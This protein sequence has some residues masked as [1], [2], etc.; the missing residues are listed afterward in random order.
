MQRSAVTALATGAAS[1]VP[2]W[3]APRGVRAAIAVGGGVA[4]AGAAFAGARV[5]EAFDG[6][7]EPVGVRPAAVIAAAAGGLMAGATLAGFAMDRSAERFLVQRGVRHPR[8]VLGAVG[9][10]LSWLADAASRRTR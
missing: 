10:G 7:H 1:V 3:R 6:T 2:I 4:V 9:A 8:L 5:P